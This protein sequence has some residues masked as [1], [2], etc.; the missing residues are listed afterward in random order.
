MVREDYIS[1]LTD[2]NVLSE[3][4]IINKRDDL[5][6]RIFEIYK[7]S[8]KTDSKSYSK[9]QKALKSEEEQFFSFDEL[10]KMLPSHLRRKQ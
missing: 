2:F 3:I 6:K 10:D 9:A 5:Q 1:L 8:P 4:E 7:V